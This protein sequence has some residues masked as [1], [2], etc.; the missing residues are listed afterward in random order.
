MTRKITRLQRHRARDIVDTDKFETM[1]ATP[2]GKFA[3]RLVMA[4]MLVTISH[5]RSATIPPLASDNVNFRGE[6]SVGSTHHR[7]D[8]EVVAEVLDG[9]ME[10]VPACVKVGHDRIQ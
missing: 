9:H 5:H 8:I 10:G 2:G 7:S 6:K 4:H 1:L 3:S